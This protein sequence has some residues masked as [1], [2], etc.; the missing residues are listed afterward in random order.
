MGKV[1]VGSGRRV[2]RRFLWPRTWGD[3]KVPNFNHEA[4][5]KGGDAETGSRRMHQ[6]LVGEEGQA[7]C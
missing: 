6:S 5:S 2:L 4:L 3:L 7:E 1:L